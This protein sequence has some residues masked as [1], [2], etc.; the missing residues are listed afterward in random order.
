[1]IEDGGLMTGEP[2]FSSRMTWRKD[3]TAG[4]AAHLVAFNQLGDHLGKQV[5]LGSLGLG[6]HRAGPVILRR[7][8]AAS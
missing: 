7:W 2:C 1:V 5:A 6:V 3:G 4:A 8:T